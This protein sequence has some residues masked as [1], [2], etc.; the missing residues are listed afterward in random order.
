PKFS[1]L[2]VH[3]DGF[4]AKS[5]DL[6]IA[7]DPPPDYSGIAAAAGGSFARIV[8]RPSELNSAIE[9]ALDAVRHQRR[10]AVLDVWLAHLMK[11]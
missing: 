7:F 10:A 8:K 6:G 2:A 4:A 3:P 1:A 9:E 11:G 5:D